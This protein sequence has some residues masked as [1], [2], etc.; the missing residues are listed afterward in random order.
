MVVERKTN[1]DY[2]I[3]DIIS[4]QSVTVAKYDVEQ[5]AMKDFYSGLTAVGRSLDIR[6]AEDG[7]YRFDA[8][9]T[10]PWGFTIVTKQIDEYLEAGLLKYRNTNPCE[11]CSSYDFCNLLIVMQTYYSIMFAVK[12]D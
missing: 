7:V 11:D 10:A 3:S 1:I 8:L 12:N 6:I 9:G 4:G 5:E 2:L